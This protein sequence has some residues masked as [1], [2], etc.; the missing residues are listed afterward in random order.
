MSPSADLSRRGKPCER[1]RR[2]LVLFA[3]GARDPRW[4]LPFE[5]IAARLRAA[6][7]DL[8][9][10]LAYL[11]LMQPSLPEAAAALAAEGCSQVDVL[12][13]FLGAGGHIRKDL[14]A[15]LAALR[16]AHPGTR[17]HAHP[18]LGEQDAMLAAIAAAALALLDA[19]APTEAGT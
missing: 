6:R 16:E 12:P 2:G 18:T 15:L 14:P 19:D 17:F 8:P 4:A 10:R 1:P 11:E 9:L 7:P 5:A 13:L 3:H